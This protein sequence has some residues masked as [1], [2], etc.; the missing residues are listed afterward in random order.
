MPKKTSK[1][2]I[3]DGAYTIVVDVVDEPSPA[4]SKRSK[5]LKSRSGDNSPANFSFHSRGGD[6][7]SENSEDEEIQ[8]GA[9][10]GDEESEE[11]EEND[12]DIDFTDVDYIL[13]N[14]DLAAPNYEDDKTFILRG[15]NDLVTMIQSQVRFYLHLAIHGFLNQPRHMTILVIGEGFIGA[16]IVADLMSCGCSEFLFVFT[17]GDLTATEWNNQGLRS[18][19]T[20]PKL[21]DGKSADI[22]ILATEN[23]SFST[24][25]NQIKANNVVQPSTFYYKLLFRVESA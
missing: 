20:F 23:T 7:D 9:Q 15:R 21:L 24:L 6:S 5:K 22:L 4:S 1:K 14:L 2:Y 16:N 12:S 13:K 19:T 8:F 25:T 18:A 11:Q 3:K 10:E 17:R